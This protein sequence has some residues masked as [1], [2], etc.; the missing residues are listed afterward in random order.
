MAKAVLVDSISDLDSD[1]IGSI[2]W[3]AGLDYQD[4]GGWD[5]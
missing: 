3:A 1:Q 4:V 2:Q 5:F